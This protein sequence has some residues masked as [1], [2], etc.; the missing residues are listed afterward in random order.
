MANGAG[1]DSH[2]RFVEVVLG[3]RSLADSVLGRPNVRFGS[4]KKTYQDFIVQMF[5]KLSAKGI[6]IASI[7]ADGQHPQ[8]MTYG[9]WKPG[10]F[11]RKYSNDPV[12]F[13]LLVLPWMC[14]I[15][16][17]CMVDLMNDLILAEAI[18][19]LNHFI[20]LLCKRDCRGFV[21]CIAKIIL[22]TR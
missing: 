19:H 10:S 2:R 8:V 16:N 7:M 22:Q 6:D 14:H 4:E 1:F 15:L 21:D 3:G 17:L 13:K 20:I 5:H 11:Q 18:G 9:H 12:L